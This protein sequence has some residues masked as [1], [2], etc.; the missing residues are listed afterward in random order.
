MDGIKK[1][2]LSIVALLVLMSAT[3]A[4]A[5]HS[6]CLYANA[7]QQCVTV[8][9]AENSQDIAAKQFLI[10][11]DGKSKIYIVRSFASVRSQA[12]QLSIDGQ[13]VANMAPY[14][15]ALIDLSPG[16]HR[17]VARSGKGAE[18]LLNTEPGK[19]Y[20]V[21]SELSLMFN[22]VSANLKILD[23]KKGQF[24]VRRAQRVGSRLDVR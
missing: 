13:P 7:H 2:L 24:Q 15:Y 4:Y 8:P 6:V 17:I 19:L 22:T 1:H 16:L 9:L 20:Y 23:E 11:T 21:E 14:T 10:P 3:H 18:V 5:A 12:L